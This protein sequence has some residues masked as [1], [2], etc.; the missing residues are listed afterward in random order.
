MREA[1]RRNRE[2]V[3]SGLLLALSLAAG[4]LAANGCGQV[5]DG[6]GGESHFLCSADKA[7]PTGY[8]CVN[9]SDASGQGECVT[10]GGSNASRIDGGASTS[11]PSPI[12]VGGSNS[13]LGMGGSS[14]STAAGAAGACSTDCCPTDPSCYSTPAG[15]GSPGS[16]CLATRD[17]TG[18]QHVQLRQTYVNVTS[19]A[20]NAAPS[21]VYQILAARTELNW[22]ACNEGANAATY[23]AGGFIEL[24]DVFTQN[25]TTRA[26]IDGDYGWDGF[27][28]YTG[29]PITAA[30]TLCYAQGSYTGIPVGGSKAPDV[31]LGPSDM[32]L[33]TGWPAKGLPPPMPLKDASGNSTPWAVAPTRNKRVAVDFDVSTEAGREAV[34]AMFDATDPSY[35]GVD[36]TGQPW[37]GIFYYDATTGY[38]H[39]FSPLSWEIVYGGT[40]AP[41]KTTVL[42]IREVERKSTVND[43]NHPDCIGDYIAT[44]AGNSCSPGGDPATNSSWGGGDCTKTTGTATCAPGTTASSTLGYSLITEIEQVWAD[45]LGSTVCIS[46]PGSQP[47]GFLSADAKT[48]VGPS[49]NP[50]APN[51]TGLPAGD[52][53]A[54]TNQPATATCH[55]AYHNVS[56]NVFQGA[57]I[58]LD[59]SGTPS[60]CSL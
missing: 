27:A 33:T 35:V 25:T 59:A 48:C 9:V 2:T 38:N 26:F 12:G 11:N 55:D 28:T 53:C 50:E 7:C 36:N 17:N 44:M 8:L 14:A 6:V 13:S 20:G 23:G 22:P 40:D 42:P 30:P 57:P 1:M 41:G 49:W 56:Y 58:Q 43:V 18:Q 31:R 47:A 4:A 51:D 3:V 37:T 45:D 29:M 46:T 10:T 19:P 16:E 39:T 5:V 52:W 15:N 60:T 24:T 32:S 54:A 34:L 21:I